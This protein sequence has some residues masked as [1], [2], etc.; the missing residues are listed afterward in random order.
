MENKKREVRIAYKFKFEYRVCESRD[1]DKEN[2]RYEKTYC[3]G[4]FT[5]VESID[6][7]LQNY[8]IFL[9][10][11][12]KYSPKSL[13]E[14]WKYWGWYLDDNEDLSEVREYHSIQNKEV[15]DLNEALSER[16]GVV[17]IAAEK[18]DVISNNF[19]SILNNE[20]F[21]D[22]E[23]S[24]IDTMASI[25]AEIKKITEQISELENLK[26]GLRKYEWAWKDR[27]ASASI[28]ILEKIVKEKRININERISHL[29]L[30]P[31]EIAQRCQNKE[32]YE[33][34]LRQG[35]IDN[36]NKWHFNPLVFNSWY[37]FFKLYPNAQELTSDDF[38]DVINSLPE[39]SD[40]EI[41]TLFIGE[42]MQMKYKDLTLSSD[43]IKAFRLS[44][45]HYI[46]SDRDSYNIICNL[47]KVLV[48]NK[49]YKVVEILKEFFFSNDLSWWVYDLS[50]FYL[51]I[52]TKNLDALKDLKVTILSTFL[53]ESH[54]GLNYAKL[55]KKYCNEEY[56]GSEMMKYINTNTVRF[57]F[58]DF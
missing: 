26:N 52:E 40:N 42:D 49:R 11:E 46:I 47:L 8:E 38:N 23:R 4:L 39:L 13:Y 32:L 6:M 36:F 19:Y 3:Y 41:E 53:G 17:F 14:D 24:R 12:K 37:G 18:D 33:T 1:P 2:I 45:E 27:C 9:D 10:I 58:D 35:A 22:F 15:D 21:I 7:N 48:N 54:L 56:L 25:E 20:L 29:D 50:L 31:L 44:F 30:Y 16:L 5:D 57:S 55:Y 34:L 51:C 28:P 43:Y